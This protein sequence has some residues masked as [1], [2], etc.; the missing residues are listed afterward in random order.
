MTNKYIL[1]I[2][3]ALMNPMIE[4]LGLGFQKWAI[5]GLQT[6]RNIAKWRAIW[7]LGFLMMV[8]VAFTAFKILSLGNASTAGAFAGFGLV[9]LTV[10]S[11]LVL[12]EKILRQ[13]LAGIA[14][15]VI[16]T[17][18]LGYFSHGHQTETVQPNNARMATFFIAYIALVIFGTFIAIKRLDTIGGAVIGMIAGSMNGV[19]YALQ[20][21]VAP[22]FMEFTHNTAVAGKILL[23]PMNY[24]MLAGGVG[25]VVVLQYAYKHGKAV[26]VVPGRAAAFIMTPVAAGLMFLGESIPPICIAS[27]ALVIVGVIITT[28]ANPSKLAH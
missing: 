24:V 13:E 26:Q 8:T 11:F 20:R 22:L 9:M 25:G 12:K 2:C 18:I 1:F 14:L 7:V 6:G 3:L 15:I 28:T 19:G 17:S 21:M 16:A 23:N 27:I 4:S 10:F 5:N